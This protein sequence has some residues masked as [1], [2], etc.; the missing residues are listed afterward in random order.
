MPAVSTD[1][2]MKHI[3]ELASD[4]YQGRLSGTRGHER[5]MAYHAIAAQIEELRRPIDKLEE[6]VDNQLWPLPKY[7]ELLFI[8]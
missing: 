1:T 3:V 2:L 8:S 6:F 5:A 7:R 4:T